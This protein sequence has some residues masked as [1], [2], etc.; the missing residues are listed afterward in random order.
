M[1]TH[2]GT[3]IPDTVCNAT[4]VFSGHDFIDA[5]EAMNDAGLLHQKNTLAGWIALIADDRGLGPA[6]V[7]VIAGVD[8]ELAAAILGGTVMGLPLS[9]LDR[10]LRAL[11]NRPH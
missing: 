11:E 2:P 5:L 8:R 3:P 7:A 10:T 6:D 9:V 1:T 4:P